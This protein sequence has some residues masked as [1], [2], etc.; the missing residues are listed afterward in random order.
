[1]AL[2]TQPRRHRGRFDASMDD[3]ALLAAVAAVLRHALPD[4]PQKATQRRFDDAR[5]PAGHPSCPT[6]RAIVMR[7]TEDANR[8]F[9]WDEIKQLALDPKRNLTQ[10]L[11]AARREAPAEHLDERHVFFALRYVARHAELAAPTRDQY[12]DQR[13]KL[14]AAARRRGDDTLAQLLPTV[15]QIERLFDGD[16]DAALAAAELV[17]AKPKP[18]PPERP[19]GHPPAEVM[20][21]FVKTN[22]WWPSAGILERFAADAGI[23]MGAVKGPIK[24]YRTEAAR[25]LA[26]EGISVLPSAKPPD[27]R[28][29]KLPPGGIPGAPRRESGKQWHERACVE[30]VARWLRG[31]PTAAKTTKTAYIA[32]ARGKTDFPS[33]SAFD[34]YGGWNAIKKKARE[35]DADEIPF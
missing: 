12:A 35:P 24:S 34:D 5:A 29:F 26:A 28:V 7:F 4:T 14:L 25:L 3:D 16:W 2:N 27:G 8:S 13:A 17:R 6:A 19:K 23:R 31:L 10:T 20:A 32:F 9:T 15:G 22:G 30:A 11:A 21:H 1:V 33:A 18:T